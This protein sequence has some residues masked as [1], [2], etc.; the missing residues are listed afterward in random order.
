M[1]PD[2]IHLCAGCASSYKSN[3]AECSRYCN[4]AG[5]CSNSQT[6]SSIHLP[7]ESAPRGSARKCSWSVVGCRVIASTFAP[8]RRRFSRS[9]ILRQTPRSRRR[10]RR[11]RCGRQTRQR[12]RQKALSAST[13][14]L[15]HHV[16]QL[17][18]RTQ[19]QN[20]AFLEPF[21]GKLVFL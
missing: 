9:S 20:R 1:C 12:P 4:R 18:R 14:S 19:K 10:T 16:A 21:R 8:R 6:R 7:N 5:L 11:I 3:H 2:K 15:F 13:E 17:P